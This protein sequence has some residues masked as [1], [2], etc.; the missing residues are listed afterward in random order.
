[1]AGIYNFILIIWSH[2]PR[3]QINVFLAETKKSCCFSYCKIIYDLINA[4]EAGQNEVSKLDW[5][6]LDR[7]SYTYEHYGNKV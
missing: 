3:W 2:H 1:M 4:G 7:F 5:G 6:Q